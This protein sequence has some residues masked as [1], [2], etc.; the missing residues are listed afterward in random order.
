MA[1]ERELAS[2]RPVRW[3]RIIDLVQQA[4]IEIAPW[5][6]K[7]DGSPVKD[8]PK[9]PK[10]CYNWAFGGEGEPTVLCIWHSTMRLLDGQIVF[11]GNLRAYAMALERATE[12]RLRS[13]KERDRAR[14]QAKRAQDFDRKLQRAFR[15][16][17]TV[18]VVSLLGEQ[19]DDGEPGVGAS[20]AEL[21]YLDPVPWTV[22]SYLDD[23]HFRL[24]RG[25]SDAEAPEATVLF[26]STP[27]FVDQF[28]LPIAPQGQIVTAKAYPRSSEVRSSVLKRAAGVCEHCRAAGFK[29]GSGAIYLETHHVVPLA[30]GGPDMEWNVLA[31]CPN[32]HARA[33]YGVDRD[34][35]RQ[36]FVCMLIEK[37]PAADQALRSHVQSHHTGT[38]GP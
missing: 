6:V 24:I 23:G 38:S 5:A 37:F 18:R 25:A 19:G 12:S 21:R 9:N 29:T 4:G 14:R 17:E 28:S 35:L 2:L 16:G 31:L 34:E 13:K 11:V 26:P 20:N 3:H 30:E 36:R 1:G 7:R 33:H 27:L 32:D 22:A 8:P 10:Y 15:R